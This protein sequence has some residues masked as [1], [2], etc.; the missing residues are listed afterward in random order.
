MNQGIWILCGLALL[1]AWPGAAAEPAIVPKPARLA[2]TRGVFR[3]GANTLL[4]TQEQTRLAGRVLEAALSLKALENGQECD[5]AVSILLDGSV[6][7]DEGYILEILP[8][9]VRIRAKSQAGAFYGAQTL[10]QLL[11]AEIYGR[12][13]PAGAAYTLPCLRIEDSPRFGWRGAMLDVSRHFMPKQEIFKFIDTLAL[14]K[15]NVLHLHLTDDQ[16]WR[17]EI[18]RYPR[19][20]EVGSMRK[21]S[22]VG[23]S[24]EKK[25]FD[26]KPHGGF[27]TQDEIREMVA[28]ARDRFVNLLPEIEMPGHAQAAVASYPVLGN[29]GVPL[30]VST[31]W[32][33]HRDVFNVE[34]NT[35]SFLQGVL[36]EVMA[37]F[38]SRFIHV[39]GDE[40]PLDQWK[41]GAEAQ[42]RMKALGLT[43]EVELH[44]YVM[45]R[46]DQ[47]LRERGRRLVGWDEILE[48]G[49]DRT[50]TVMSWRGNKGGIAAARAGHDVVM[51][52][53]THTYLDYYQS[54]APGEPLAI[55]SFLP[56]D[57]VYAFDPVPAELS[58][59]EARHI[60][61]TQGQLWSEYIPTPEHLEYMA[62]PR[63]TALAEVA[64]TP[65]ERKN[66]QDFLGRLKVNERRLKAMG[67]NFRPAEGAQ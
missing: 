42:A 52:P 33:I 48:G 40:V 30:E 60:L 9:R 20:T 14:H 65:A 17:I 56:L 23:H 32:G 1:S 29:T 28:Y 53:N 66:Y 59:E 6:S 12:T 43:K 63:L 11:P 46:M 26:G 62:F 8:R 57:Q 37:L 50:A 54:K 25:G 47:F 34:D 24:R 4:V 49:V 19:L 38:P 3:L 27:Y 16:G 64:W 61:G 10:L 45:K 13:K 44:G 21:E 67:V 51:A 36:D 55:G 58:P 15:M 5:G 39:G 2:Q 35:L 31:H 18:K 7:A 22:P 41:A